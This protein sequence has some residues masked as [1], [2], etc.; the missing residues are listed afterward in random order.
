M[1]C[2]LTHATARRLI[3]SPACHASGR[4]AGPSAVSR[5]Y[6]QTLPVCACLQLS[7]V[8]LPPLSQAGTGKLGKCLLLPHRHDAPTAGL[9][10]GRG[11]RRWLKRPE[12][13]KSFDLD[14]ETH[15]TLAGMNVHDRD[16]LVLAARESDPILP[17]RPQARA[18]SRPGR[19]L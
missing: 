14:R 6:V 7:S 15:S 2:A 5:C 18:P 9:A 8:P 19:Y 4:W 1:Q 13:L 3:H 12:P 17:S 11:R 16:L 10:G